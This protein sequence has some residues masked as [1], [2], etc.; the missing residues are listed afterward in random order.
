MLLTLVS[1][2]LRWSVGDPHAD[3]SKTRLELSF[4]GRGRPLASPARDC[5][6][7]CQEETVAK[8]TCPALRLAPA[9]ATLAECR[10]I[11]RSDTHRML[12]FLGNRC[13]VN[14]QHG[15]VAADEPIRL[16]Q[17]FGF[18][19]RCIPDPSRNEVVQLIAL[20]ERKL[21]S[22]RLDALAIARADQP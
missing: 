4:C 19:R 2:P 14:H 3:R 17:Q 20:A 15:I 6:P 13:V 18:H 16:N 22:H 9:S 21:P 12:A 10:S 1:D 7:N 5:L 11:L 8:P